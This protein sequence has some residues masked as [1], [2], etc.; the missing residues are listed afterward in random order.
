MDATPSMI[1]FKNIQLSF[2]GTERQPPSALTLALMLSKVMA[3]FAKN[4]KHDAAMTTE[5]RL[6]SVI[7]ALHA[8][9]GFLSRW[10]L[11]DDKQKAVLHLVIGTSAGSRNIIQ[12]HLNFYRWKDSAF[13][14]DLLKSS[15]WLVNATCK[16]AK[17]PFKQLLVVTSEIQ[18]MF[19]RGHIHQYVE[20]T[21]RVKASARAKHRPSVQEWDRAVSYTCIMWAVQK[22]MLTFF[23]DETDPKYIQAVDTL[24]NGFLARQVT[25][26]SFISPNFSLIYEC[27][28]LTWNMSLEKSCQKQIRFQ[29]MTGSPPALWR[30]Y[31][32]EIMTCVEANIRNWNVKHLSLWG[33]LVTPEVCSASGAVVSAVDVEEAEEATTVAMF[34]EMKTKISP[35]SSMSFDLFKTWLTFLSKLSQNLIMFHKFSISPLASHHTPPLTRPA[36][37]MDEAAWAR[38]Q[39]TLGK[40]AARE[41]I[42]KVQHAKNQNTIGTGRLIAKSSNILISNQKNLITAQS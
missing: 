13:T 32:E 10:Q 15:R 38:Y 37:R 2:R 29:P 5:Q 18:E 11:D 24:H 20:A 23:G 35:F 7:C 6:K 12:S 19:L 42:L 16:T 28:F 17:E 22:E 30:D 3:D 33:E 25:L 14:S 39:H 40:K 21:R 41:H 36:P 31:M 34:Q 26:W 8:C 27:V 9:D 1:C 4:G